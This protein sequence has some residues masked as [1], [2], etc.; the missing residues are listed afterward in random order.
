MDGK[1]L[2]RTLRGLLS[3]DSN[4]DFL[5][6]LESY[7]YLY[8]AAVEFVSRTKCLKN[9]AEITTV[10][11]QA[12]YTLP[13]N[14]LEVYMRTADRR[15]YVIYND[16]SENYF[17]YEKDY[18]SI[19]YSD[20]TDSVDI[21]DHFAIIDVPNL[22]SRITGTTTSAGA[23][24]GG[25]CTLNDSGGSFLT[26]VSVNDTVH[27]TT[28]GSMGIVLEVTS[29]TA[30][31]TALFEGTNDDWSNGDTYVIQPQGRIK[32]VLDPPP[33]TANETLTV[34]YIQRP[35]PVFSDYGIYRFQNQYMTALV[36]YAAWLYKYKD[37]EPNF[38]DAF[39]TYWNEMV[40]RASAQINKTLNRTGFKV[41]FKKRR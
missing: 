21:P 18:E 23:A 40:G 2:L 28:D 41:N 4:S 37:S 3:E 32:I 29:D 14:F 19:V 13:A 6:D 27:N 35:N 7:Q 26:T 25:E 11:D 8:E 31:L 24:S 38:G 15:L 30:L 12:S 33:A 9:S 5:Q 20:N 17:L 36:K 34:H 16:G 22:D 39:F 1:R 10:A